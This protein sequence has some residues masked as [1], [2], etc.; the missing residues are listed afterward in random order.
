MALPRSTMGT[1]LRVV[2]ALRVV[3]AFVVVVGGAAAATVGN[4]LDSC[5][6]GWSTSSYSGVLV[7]IGFCEFAEVP[8]STMC[9]EEATP[10]SAKS[11]CNHPVIVLMPKWL[12]LLLLMATIVMPATVDAAEAAAAAAALAVSAAMA[13][14]AVTAAVVTG[15]RISP[16]QAGQ[17]MRRHCHT[18]KQAI[19]GRLIVS[20]QSVPISSEFRPA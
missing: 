1:P 10:I 20:P 3:V 16:Q 12:S 2:A 18:T 19:W 5:S 11:S 15:S 6:K 8:A 7:E 14:V 9:V 17:N 4:V 13:A